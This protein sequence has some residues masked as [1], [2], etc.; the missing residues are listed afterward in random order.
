MRPIRSLAVPSLLA[1]I[2]LGG[3]A[4]QAEAPGA[5]W[6]VATESSPVVEGA[7]STLTVFEIGPGDAF[8]ILGEEKGVDALDMLWLDARRLLAISDR[9]ERGATVHLFLDGRKEARVIGVTPDLFALKDGESLSMVWELVVDRRGTAYVQQCLRWKDAGPMPRCAAWGWSALDLDA[10]VARPAV[11]KRP[12]GVPTREPGDRTPAGLDVGRLPRVATPPGYGV[13]LHKTDMPADSAMMGTGRG[14]PAFTCQGPTGDAVMWPRPD[15]INWEFTTR[16][17]KAT[18]ISN[19]P[20]LLRVDGP[21]TN[22]IGMSGPSWQVFEG[23]AREP[24]ES[25]RFFGD[26]LWMSYAS[27][28]DG[29]RVV[30]GAWTLRKGSRVLGTAAGDR[31]DVVAIRR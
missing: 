31:F 1:A 11:R 10:A 29:V 13:R 3:A 28:L 30:G 2:L 16:P 20:P 5:V 22:P 15:T 7:V 4:A 12:A 14:V 25:V 19:D 6:R 17:K 23:C 27:E 9:G 21:A 26:G 18:W 8:S 24:F